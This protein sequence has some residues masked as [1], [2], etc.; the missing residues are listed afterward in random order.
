MKKNY[1]ALKSASIILLS[2][3]SDGWKY[4]RKNSNKGV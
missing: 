2:V 1:D 4:C 3:G